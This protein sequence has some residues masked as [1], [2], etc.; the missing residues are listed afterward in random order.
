MHQKVEHCLLVLSIYCIL[1]SATIQKGTPRKYNA[2]F[3]AFNHVNVDQNT[4]RGV[5]LC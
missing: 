1:C 2:K 4:V 5:A 3:Y